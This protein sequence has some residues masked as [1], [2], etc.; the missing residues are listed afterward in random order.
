M[1][2]KLLLANET[3]GC[4]CLCVCI[5]K[6]FQLPFYWML[7]IYMVCFVYIIIFSFSNHFVSEISLL[8]PFTDKGRD[9]AHGS[10]FNSWTNDEST[11][12]MQIHLTQIF[13]M[14]KLPS[15]SCDGCEIKRCLVI[16]WLTICWRVFNSKS[17]FMRNKSKWMRICPNLNAAFK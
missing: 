15:S 10:C 2:K 16:H 4:M 12:H 13:F 11:N 3:H 1:E 17:C 14:M 8:I 5:L 6:Y 7:Y 9:I